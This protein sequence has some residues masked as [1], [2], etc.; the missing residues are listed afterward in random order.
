MI[1]TIEAMQARRNGVQRGNIKR[2][3][4]RIRVND[5]GYVLVENKQL[6]VDWYK[7]QQLMQEENGT[8]LKECQQVNY[9]KVFKD[10]KQLEDQQA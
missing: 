8:L 3:L 9:N 10:I 4:A 5:V 1:C 2:L 7:E 6:E